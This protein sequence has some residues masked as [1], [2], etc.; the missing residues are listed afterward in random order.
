MSC[1]V[2]EVIFIL[3]LLKWFFGFFSFRTPAGAPPLD[4]IGPSSG[5]P[6]NTLGISSRISTCGVM[7]NCLIS[8]FTLVK[9]SPFAPC[10][11]IYYFM[12][13]TDTVKAL[14]GLSA[15]CNPLDLTIMNAQFA[16]DCVKEDH[17][18]MNID[19]SEKTDFVYK[20]ERV[21]SCQLFSAK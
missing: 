10:C 20:S 8:N 19:N 12:Q 7:K 16:T 5:I 3:I 9:L 18:S 6:F 21:S 11:A 4:P 2:I 15:R 1:R 17:L 14:A 13:N